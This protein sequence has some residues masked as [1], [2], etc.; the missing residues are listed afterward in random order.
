M[1]LP[2]LLPSFSIPCHL[3][4]DLVWKFEVTPSSLLFFLQTSNPLNVLLKQIAPHPTLFGEFLGFYFGGINKL[5]F[6]PGMVGERLFVDSGFG[7]GFE[8]P[9][10]CLLG[11]ICTTGDDFRQGVGPT[12]NTIEIKVRS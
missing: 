4:C 8:A 10:S 3:C 7:D 12:V 1:K 9:L 2:F 6:Q 5:L 11:G